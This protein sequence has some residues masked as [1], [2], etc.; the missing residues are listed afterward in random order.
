MF[1]E[2]NEDMLTIIEVSL[3]KSVLNKRGHCIVFHRNEKS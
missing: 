2:K 1:W 3:F